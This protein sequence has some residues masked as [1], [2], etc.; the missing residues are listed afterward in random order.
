MDDESKSDPSPPDHQNNKSSVF[1]CLGTP[2]L[3]LAVYVLSTGPVARYYYLYGKSTPPAYI[4]RVYSP[5]G[6]LVHHNGQIEKFFT[7][8]LEDVWGCRSA[9]PKQI[10]STPPAPTVTTN[11]QL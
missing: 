7:W 10:Q 3:L 4:V 11:K 5:L 2:L 6:S 9:A 1:W 8:Y